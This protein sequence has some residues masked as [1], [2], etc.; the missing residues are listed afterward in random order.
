MRSS[1][2]AYSVTSGHSLCAVIV[3]VRLSVR[4]KKRIVRHSFSRSD[5]GKVAVEVSDAVR[6]IG[7]SL[8]LKHI[9]SSAG[10][11]LYKWRTFKTLA[12]MLSSYPDC[13]M[14]RLT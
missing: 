10:L 2:L 14:L 1:Y 9:D 3:L 11:L 7:R 4:G 13:Q 6:T 5:R 8:C 12:L